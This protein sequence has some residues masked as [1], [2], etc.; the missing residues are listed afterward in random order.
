MRVVAVGSIAVGLLTVFGAAAAAQPSP[1]FTRDDYRIAA[2]PR[3]IVAADFNR[4]GWIDVATAGAQ[5]GVGVLLNNGHAGGFTRL[6]DRTITSSSP[7]TPPARGASSTATGKGSS[8]G[9][10]GSAAS[11]IRKASLP[12]TSTGTAASTLRLPAPASTWSRSFT[13]SQAAVSCR[14]T[15]RSEPLST[16]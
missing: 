12:P 1:T 11:H 15:S 5:G 4:D 2:A 3:A 7:S 16:S 14:R 13:R 10:I 9:R 8:S 6:A